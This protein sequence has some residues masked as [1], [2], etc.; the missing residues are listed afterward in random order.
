MSHDP[1]MR[2]VVRRMDAQGITRPELVRALEISQQ[3]FTNWRN[4]GIPPAAYQQLAEALGCSVDE[5]L[6]RP[7]ERFSAIEK[8]LIQLFRLCSPA[9][10]NDLVSMAHVW[11]EAN[12]PAPPLFR[13]VEKAR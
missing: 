7:V 9:H 13:R 8:K 2:E 6:G 10:Q 4:R 11:A 5:L 3:T 12:K 1:V